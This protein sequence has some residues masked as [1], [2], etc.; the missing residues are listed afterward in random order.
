M[1][2][3]YCLRIAFV[4]SLTTLLS[5]PAAATASVEQRDSVARLGQRAQFLAAEAA[6][7]G[8]QLSTFREIKQSLEG[9]PLLPYLE[10]EELRS[11]L[12]RTSNAQ[13][14][15]FL[16]RYPASPLA[17]RLRNRWLDRLA[18]AKRWQDY[19]DFYQPTQDTPRQCLHLYALIETG[20]PQEAFAE[21]PELW[22]YG[23]SRPKECD[24]V[25]AAWRDAGKLTPGLVWQRIALAMQAR[26]TRLARY[27]ERFLP[28]SE[29]PWVSLWLDLDRDPS[30]ALRDQRL[31]EA[32]PRRNEMLLHAVKR[33]AATDPQA[34][35]HLW[36]Q[37]D[38]RYRFNAEETALANRVLALAMVRRDQPDAL[39][40]LD[41]ANPG[42]QDLGLH[43]T[44]ILAALRASDWKRV[45]RWID[46][47][48]QQEGKSERWSY[49]RS[50]ALGEL[51]RP[52]EAHT[53]LQEVAKER[54]Y[55]GFLAADRVGAHYN[56]QH[57]SLPVGA[58]EK[59]QINSMP[60]FQRAY[61]LY[62]LGRYPQARVE[63]N[64]AT[65]PL[66]QRQLQV[67]AKL[68]EGWGWHDRAI[69]TLART[70]YWDDLEL[71]FPLEHRAP[72]ERQARAEQ[73]D[74]AWVFAIVRQESA[75]MPDAR[76]RAGALGLMQLMPATAKEQVRRTQ[77]G[78]GF[79]TNLLLDPEANIRIG[80]GY[81]GRVYQQLYQHP[82]LATAAYNAGPHRVRQWLP[83]DE[84]PADLWIETIPF[85]ET[86]TYVRRVLA[87]TVIYQQRLNGE[88]DRI[89]ERLRPIGTEASL[90]AQT[91]A[92]R[93]SQG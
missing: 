50:R 65:R 24:P 45:L 81:L 32:Q 71:R 8:G 46:A 2:P 48:P 56:L 4:V 31:A 27:L 12:P 18:E 58:Q 20:R 40:W 9:Y 49:W 29:R 72:I 33:Q 75:F 77:P 61:E 42:E 62:R 53:I 47:L 73:L 57:V 26:E 17:H 52:D 39:K 11:R 88:V 80:A 38:R 78:T 92:G 37:L 14:E 16:T 68:A 7:K 6:L 84:L 90:A 23:K 93:T 41:A 82:V 13:I 83:D 19:L 74:S 60:G 85:S 28:G 15:A 5:V 63:W 54:S 30:L 34:A 36:R 22:L 10:Y 66:D 89:S 1:N 59:D 51:G 76:S 67:A 69:F 43:E 70:G 44:R 79:K 55:Y 86:R 35:E 25:F 64:Y 91:G 3:S 87:Y 21:V